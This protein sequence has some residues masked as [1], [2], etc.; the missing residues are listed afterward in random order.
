MQVYGFLHPIINGSK[1]DRIVRIEYIKPLLMEKES[2]LHAASEPKP[3][4][5]SLL[6]LL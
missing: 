6:P 5:Q 1:G 4:S 2:Q 3:L